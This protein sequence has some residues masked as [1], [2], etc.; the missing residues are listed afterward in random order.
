MITKK[1]GNENKLVD[2]AKQIGV[3]ASTIR[4]WKA[5]DKWEDEM[6]ESAP[7]SKESAPISKR[8]ALKSKRRPT[9]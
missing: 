1:S 5:Q 3:P 7:K 6:K 9:R 8:N 4:K 2:I